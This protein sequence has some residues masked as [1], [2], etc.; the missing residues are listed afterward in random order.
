[1]LIE[2]N[3]IRDV[4]NTSVEV[5]LLTRQLA[6]DSS[7]HTHYVTDMEFQAEFQPFLKPLVNETSSAFSLNSLPALLVLLVGIMMSSHIQS[8]ALGS[9]I[10]NGGGTFWQAPLSPAVSIISC[11]TFHSQGL[12]SRLARPLNCLPPLPS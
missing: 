6:D 5:E 1:M 4:L 9:M 12:P 11:Y 10:H 3:H 2:S 7:S 8:S